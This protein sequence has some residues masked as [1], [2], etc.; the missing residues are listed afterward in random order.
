MSV[1]KPVLIGQSANFRVHA[2][3]LCLSTRS[4]AEEEEK[5]EEK[6]TK[7]FSR[8]N[9]CVH[10][11]ASVHRSK[12]D[13]IKLLCIDTNCDVASLPIEPYGKNRGHILFSGRDVR[14]TCV[15]VLCSFH[16]FDLLIHSLTHSL[17]R[18]LTQLLT[19]SP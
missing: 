6:I 10:F 3:Y 16:W 2:P 4:S 5:E 19:H 15:C 12:K 1:D 9:V 18:S 14:V 17:T 7:I 11:E 13:R 8:E